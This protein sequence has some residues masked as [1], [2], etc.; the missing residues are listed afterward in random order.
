MLRM[1]RVSS[2][3]DAGRL[4]ALVAAPGLDTRVWV[5]ICVLAADA[6]VTDDGVFADVH[7][8]ATATLD[9][10]GNV[11]AQEE[12]VRVEPDFAGDGFGFFLSRPKEGD[13]VVC[14]WPNGNYSGGGV[15]VKRLWSPAAQVP[16]KAV[17]NPDDCLLLLDKDRTL[18]M[19]VQGQGNVAL[20]V[21]QGKVLLAAESGTLAVARKTDK[22][23][24]SAAMAAWA[25]IVETF[26]NG[27]APGTFTPANNFAGPP[28]APLPAN[29]G[30]SD[31]FGSITQGSNKTESA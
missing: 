7:V 19:Q 14:V 10:D 29:P 8:L 1:S 24:A 30:G 16:K 15:L 3:M 12:T 20:I 9:D 4:G 17:D 13:E 22:L 5:S 2:R 26:V 27:I 21:D 11:I 28:L 31:N 23:T 18:R 6:N 25:L